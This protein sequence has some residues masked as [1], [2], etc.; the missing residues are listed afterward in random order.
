MSTEEPTGAPVI[1]VGVS[2]SGSPAALGWA[3]DVAGLVK[4][5]VRAVLAWR[6]PR[7]P[8]APGGHPPAV[9]ST[10]PDD[11]AEVAQARIEQLVT[12]AL[13]EGHGVECVAV[14]GGAVSA[15]LRASA[16]ADLL[17][18][19]SPRPSTLAKVSAKVVAPQLIYRSS[20]PVVVMPPP[21]KGEGTTSRMRRGAG[22]LAAAL[23]SAAG[24]AGRPG[25]P[26]IPP[27][28]E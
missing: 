12:A 1:V 11:P 6:P 22:R 7:P 18:I 23:A 10:G 5:H 8:S 15:L 13:G 26:P 20:C 28:P 4:G 17:V 25:I 21:A 19:D 9:A 3:V 14:H 24:S 2:R 16:D 27:G